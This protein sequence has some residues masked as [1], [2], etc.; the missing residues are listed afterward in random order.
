M[1]P[2]L[3]SPSDISAKNNPRIPMSAGRCPCVI[4]LIIQNQCIIDSSFLFPLSDM[5]YQLPL[6]KVSRQ[7]PPLSKPGLHQQT[8]FCTE[9][10]SASKN[11]V[12]EFPGIRK[13]TAETVPLSSY[14]IKSSAPTSPPK[15]SADSRSSYPAAS[16]S[17]PPR[18]QAS[19]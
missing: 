19:R 6:Y 2:L 8:I 3:Y 15:E 7:T 17:S 10:L 4:A 11:Q 9:W 1:C 5:R 18:P 13:R 12:Q 16:G 14:H